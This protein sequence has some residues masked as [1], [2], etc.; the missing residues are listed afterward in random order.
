MAFRAGQQF[1]RTDH[2]AAENAPR[3]ELA[4]RVAEAR[5]LRVVRSP[6]HSGRKEN[7]TEATLAP[8]RACA[9]PLATGDC[10]DGLL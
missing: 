9:A 2:P 5:S 7:L 6:W 4:N 8:F 10:Y 3:V 1:E